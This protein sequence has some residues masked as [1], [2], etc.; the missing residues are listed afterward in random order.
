M[1]F[2]FSPFLD[3]ILPRHATRSEYT[4]RRYRDSLLFNILVTLALCIALALLTKIGHSNVLTNLFSLSVV[5]CLV[6]L[7]LLR[8]NL[9]LTF[10]NA[11]S[12][13]IVSS[14]VSIL[15]SVTGGLDSPVTS[16]MV[17]L[18]LVTIILMRGK[19][20]M[21]LLVFQ[22]IPL[23]GFVYSETVGM[24]MPQV[25]E[26]KYFVRAQIFSIVSAWLVGV[27]SL[28]SHRYWQSELQSSLSTSAH[29]DSLTGLLTRGHF[30]SQARQNL[31]Y[32]ARDHDQLSFVMID[33]DRL[34]LINDDHGHAVGDQVIR[35]VAKIVLKEL[36]AGDFCGRIGGDE[37]CAVLLGASKEDAERVADR[38][39]AA[40]SNVSPRRQRDVVTPVSISV[41]IST[42]DGVGD[43]NT[44]EHYIS[45]ADE[46]MYQQKALHKAM[47]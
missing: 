2:S 3:T 30:E 20:A 44:I 39:S 31:K 34:K 25:L 37:F 15:A 24:S 47:I 18:P 16:W 40:V 12:V 42:Y 22:G 1:K 4:H 17:A 7:A 10:V 41:G 8:T 26:P 27:I 21:A 19:L 9:S 11:I 29:I 5:A 23:L 32:A 6:M 35:L 38:L 13:L 36:R 33:M 28:A 46:K 45:L 14:L 43:S